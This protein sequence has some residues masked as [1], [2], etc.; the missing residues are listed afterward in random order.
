MSALQ[1]IDFFILDFIQ[2]YLRFDFLDRIMILITKL[3]D[4]GAIWIVISVIFLITD[5]YRKIG[6][7]MAVALFLSLILGNGLLKGLVG[8]ERPFLVKDFSILIPPPT[9][10]SFPSAHTMSSF[11]A[12]FSV[13]LIKKKM[14][15]VFLCL[16][17]LIGISR[18][19]LYVHFPTDV[20]SGILF[21]I[22]F[23][24]IGTALV[25]KKLRFNRRF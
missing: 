5:K 11:A 12:A 25:Y 15:I 2:S 6:A 24:Y 9:G 10:T 4:M 20:I 14:G 17:L 16:A 13:F 21:G 8:R 3:G 18:M 19:Y 22:L 1:N 7:C 23:G